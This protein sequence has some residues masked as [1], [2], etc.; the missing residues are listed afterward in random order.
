M[1]AR[2]AR[3]SR[4]VV[5][6]GLFLGAATAE[7][8]RADAAARTVVLVTLDGLL[9]E[10]YLHPDSHGLR[11][12]TLRR[13]VA[14][15]ASSDGVLSVFPSVTYPAHSS[16]ATGVSPGRH[17]IV[18]NRTRDPLE[19]NLE[20]WHWYSDDL[21][22]TP[23]WRTA[24]R[25]GLKTGLLAWPV[26]VGAEASWVLPEFVRARTEDDVKLV[27]ALTSRRL[28][29]GLV[30]ARPDVWKS[31]QP[32]GVNDEFV[33]TA[34]A[35][36]VQE[37]R[38]RLLLIHLV[39]V[40]EAQ[41]KTGLWSKDTV[42]AIEATD[43]RLS[44]IVEATKT[45]G[46]FAETTFLVASDHGFAPVTRAVRPGALLREAGLVQVDAQQKVTASRA[47]VVTSAGQAY[48]YLEGGAPGSGETVRRAFDAQ[49]AR[50]DGGIARIYDRAAIGA[51][52]GDP[53]AFL[54]LEAQ[55]GTT[56]VA[57]YAGPYLAPSTTTRA[58]H[59][60]DPNRPEMQASLLALGKGIAHGKIEGARL[61]DLAPTIAAWLGLSLPDA[62]GRN[63]FPPTPKRH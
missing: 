52:K 59:G 3:A 42:D 40:D 54:A 1:S 45:A 32:E 43:Q 33:T 6:A 38:P 13:F 25:A 29:A 24:E 44:R 10:S 26:T 53:E 50:P 17:G 2:L 22:A 60:Y 15:G 47:S 7:E 37:E 14:E 56:F 30:A 28:A 61:I 9:P 21:R 12:P 8:R 19:K 5:L 46:T 16:I 41:H 49:A 11:V 27:R 62:E 35:W 57:G 34:A 55:P 23:I 39:A 51:A 36:L 4:L 58:T 63:L 31:Y 20:G 48:V 18:S